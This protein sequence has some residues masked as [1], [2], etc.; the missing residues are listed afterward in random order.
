MLWIAVDD[1][2]K[3]VRAGSW[4]PRPCARAATIRCL[5]YVGGS[6]DRPSADHL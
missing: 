4:E 5:A 6:S 1:E 3:R 2:A